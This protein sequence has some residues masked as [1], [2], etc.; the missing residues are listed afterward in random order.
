VTD[1]LTPVSAPPGPDLRTNLLWYRV[2]AYTVGIGLIVLVFVGIPL[3]IWAHNSTVEAIVGTAH[4]WLYMAYLVAA[5]LLTRKANW[6]IRRTIVIALAG[7]IPIGSF[8][9]ERYVTR[10]AR[11]GT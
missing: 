10:W 7:T 1:Q 11:T 4:G 6:S 9:C 5:F 2:I 3:Q 8:V